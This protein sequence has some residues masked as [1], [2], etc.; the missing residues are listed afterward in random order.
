MQLKCQKYLALVQIF[1]HLKDKNLNLQNL[2]FSKIYKSPSKKFLTR[3][4][5]YKVGQTNN[6]R[7]K[8]TQI[9][10]DCYY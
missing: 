8:L 10:S 7:D 5:I 6:K 9:F 2:D 4:Y 1:C 3:I